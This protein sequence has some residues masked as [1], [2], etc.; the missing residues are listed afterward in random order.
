MRQTVHSREGQIILESK[1]NWMEVCRRRIN[2]ESFVARLGG[3][4]RD[5]HGVHSQERE[6][7]REQNDRRS[8]SAPGGCWVCTWPRSVCNTHQISQMASEITERC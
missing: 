5:R 7:R 8:S 2:T 3:G 1:V 4:T 6:G